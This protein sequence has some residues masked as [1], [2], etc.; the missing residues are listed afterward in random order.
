MVR[1]SPSALFL[2]GAVALTAAVGIAARS[3]S[4][5][6]DHA[7]VL[8]SDAAALG[9]VAVGPAVQGV[10]M[11]DAT[12]PFRIELGHG[13][14]HGGPAGAAS[15]AR[16]RAIVARELAR[17]PR[18]FL[19]AARLR[20]VVFTDDLHEG[21]NPIPSLPN[22]ASLLLL[23][24]AGSESDLVRGLHHEIFHFADL[25]DDGSV[26]PDPA[27]DELNTPG[28]AYGAGGRTLR[29]AWAARPPD[30]D[31]FVSG[32]FVS[33]YATSGVE[34]DKAE[35]FAFAMARPAEVRAQ[36]ARDAV[37]AAKLHELARR[38]GK[39]DP[40]A[41]RVLGLEKRPSPPAPLP[42][43]EGR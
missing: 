22:V 15:L 40:E 20:G 4:G 24:V 33:S 36:A 43:G 5:S 32:G 16:A 6:E 7:S 14:V 17:Y 19:G 37:V 29:A 18:A 31:G 13:P 41:P 39:L 12:R 23:D 11:V 27:W 26:S 25:A 35:T 21:D 3:A 10:A 34:E 38:V 30:D 42:E 1:P 28:F 9:F 2:C 8:P